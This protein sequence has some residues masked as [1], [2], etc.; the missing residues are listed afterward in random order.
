MTSDDALYKFRL[1]VFALAGELD[2]VWAACRAMGC[3]TR[4]TRRH[5]LNTRAKRLALVAGYSAPP[6]GER[7]PAQC[8]KPA[9]ARHLLPG[10]TGLREELRRYLRY[11]TPIGRTRAD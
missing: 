8:W 11:T 1:R 10:L 7:P 9:F 4:P 2:N 3:T 5:G 6:L